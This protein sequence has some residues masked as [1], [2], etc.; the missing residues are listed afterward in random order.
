[1]RGDGPAGPSARARCCE[2]AQSS[3]GAPK[4]RTTC[5]T[6]GR[7]GHRVSEATTAAILASEDARE[8]TR[9]NP[10]YCE[11]PSCNVLYYG[12]DGG[13]ASKDE[14]V[15]RVGIKETAEP[16]PVCYCFG[17]TR[18]HLVRELRAGSSA[19]LDPIVSEVRAGR[20]ACETKNPS[21]KCC[22]AEMRGLI[23]QSR[24]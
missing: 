7:E 4:V 16:I 6:C 23:V 13:F 21:G 17:I 15:T 3:A 18:A 12:E 11:T 24:G 5:P 19:L 1:M 22:L 9:T 8:R 14:A 20:C 2:E 10:R